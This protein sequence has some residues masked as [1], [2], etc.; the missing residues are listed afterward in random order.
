MSNAFD[1]IDI[2]IDTDNNNFCLHDKLTL[3]ISIKNKSDVIVENGLFRLILD[4]NIFR[5]LD[6]NFKVCIKDFGSI[7][8]INPQESIN[9]EIPIEI[10]EV[11]KEQNLTISALLNF[12]IIDKVNN[13]IDLNCKSNDLIVSLIDL[14]ILKEDDFQITTSK[15]IYFI[16]EY[17]DFNLTLKNSG[18]YS[19]NNIK[20]TNYI[21]KDTYLIPD[22]IYSYDL[23]KL[24]ITNNSIIVT[25][26]DYN[27]QIDINFKISVLENININEINSNP[28]INYKDKS[29]RNIEVNSNPILVLLSEKNILI[30]DNFKYYIDKNEVFENDIITHTISIKNNTNTTIS[31]LFLTYNCDSK[32]EFI[33][34]SITVNEIYRVLEDMSTPLILG[35]LDP[36]EDAIINFKTKVY[37]SHDSVSANFSINYDTSRRNISQVSNI[38]EYKVL[39]PIFNDTSFIKTLDKDLY[40]LDDIC[41][42][43]IHL[44]NIGNTSAYNVI[45]KDSLLPNLE[46][47]NNSLLVNNVKSDNDIF[48]DGLYFDKLEPNKRVTIKYK[49]KAIDI[50]KSKKTN[51][52]ITYS[53]ENK[54]EPCNAYS[55]KSNLS[56]L[57]AKIGNNNIKKELSSYSCQIGD[58][59]TARITIENTG[60]IDCESLKVSETF[61]K[62]LELIEGSL[63]INNKQELED[64]IF[65]GINIDRV[66]SLETTV[67]T[68]QIKVLDFPKPNPIIDRTKLTY[69]FI[70]GDKLQS[71]VVYSTKSKLYINN[72]DMYIVDNNAVLKDNEFS[73]ICHCGDYLFFSFLIENVGNVGLESIILNLNLPKDLSLNV[74]SV[75]INNSLYNKKFKNT[76]ELPNLNV[77]QKIHVDFFVKH[78]LIKDYNLESSFYFEYIF[79]DLQTKTPFKKSTKFKSNIVIINPDIEITKFV[80]DQDIEIDREFTKNI[81][82]TNTGNIVLEDIK[83]NLNESNFLQNSDTTI[84]VNGEYIDR[85]SIINF[86]KLDINETINIAIR[87]NTI[88]ISLC[89]ST[90]PESEVFANY[91]LFD[92]NKPIPI[93][94]KSNKLKL[95]IKNYKLDSK[96][97]CSS[98]ILMLD[99]IYRYTISIVNTGNINCD[100]VNLDINI[101]SCLEYIKDSLCSNSKNLNLN[102]ICSNISID[103]LKCNESINVIFDFI[104]KSIPFKGQAEIGLAV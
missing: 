92:K 83:L 71:G 51:A 77:A 17:I 72:P 85:S 25:D 22:S 56:I 64:N 65:N 80:S 84:F 33:K 12:H 58:I 41:E 46:F 3:K 10:K 91:Y 7:D 28:K 45:L 29:L 24:I 16:D 94:K 35:E 15:N 1:Y 67:I 21:P 90:L 44:I 70:L 63:F 61:N 54:D 20:I 78:S 52:F 68:Y 37:N 27:E 86:D 87:Y 23:D 79:R 2:S 48:Y 93:R 31:N 34:N 42:T 53:I 98:N 5:V 32:F 101:P 26:L 55:S 99:N 104:V 43:T 19:L 36:N 57:G 73:K 96:C 6:E 4:T 9:F 76:L 50:C 89:E 81:N 30:E 66:K 95:D 39:N 62:S 75:K 47:I 97:K 40:L 100:L 8:S 59:I 103:S 18:N 11:P 82:L 38:Q 49:S 60:N 69:S 102:K 14:N 74:E 13:I 88:D